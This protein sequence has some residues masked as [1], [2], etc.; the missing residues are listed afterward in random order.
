MILFDDEESENAASGEWSVPFTPSDTASSRATP[1]RDVSK[2]AFRIV[3]DNP[4]GGVVVKKFRS[5]QAAVAY[6]IS[7][8][9]TSTRRLVF[10]VARI[11]KTVTEAS[12]PMATAAIV[13]YGIGMKL[14]AFFAAFLIAIGFVA[15]LIPAFRDFGVL[16]PAGLL[17][18][19][20]VGAIARKG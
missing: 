5:K 3:K 19:W 8:D 13:N 2:S 10:E 16:F 9:T 11:K 14:A 17:L 12:K 6:A 15:A 7:Q 1:Y 20:I 4:S 18:F